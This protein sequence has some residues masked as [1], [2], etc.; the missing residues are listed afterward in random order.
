MKRFLADNY[1]Y[2]LYIISLDNKT[3]KRRTATGKR[4]GIITLGIDPSKNNLV[5]Y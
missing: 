1:K 4:V 5:S 3:H 2:Q